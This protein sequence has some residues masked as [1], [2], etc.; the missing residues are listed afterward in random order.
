M[1]QVL[2][3][4]NYSAFEEI[5]DVKNITTSNV[6]T[7]AIY[8]EMLCDKFKN[9]G[10]SGKVRSDAKKQEQRAADIR[11]LSPRVY[12]IKYGGVSAYDNKYRTGT[13]NGQNYMSSEDFAAYYKDLRRYKMPHYYS[14]PSFE[15]DKAD[16]E[17]QRQAQEEAG[18]LPKK[19]LW[20]AMIREQTEKIK[21]VNAEE[22]KNFSYEWF[23][24]DSREDRREVKGKRIP[25][26]I[27]PTFALVTISLFMIVAS[28]VMVSREHRQVARLEREITNLEEIKSELNTKLEIKDNM[29]MI[30]EI[31]VGRYGMVSREYVNSKYID[32]EGGEYIDAYGKKKD[33]SM[34]ASILKAIGLKAE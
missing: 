14:R 21:R 33:E 17:A 11:K 22:L 30:K 26:K 29:I 31:A 1:K 3:T 4:E 8:I 32:L 5:R 2:K 6:D 25:K 9:R 7:S 23:P 12:D 20:L 16:I 34:L 18:T 19:A 24:V 10:I 27:I 13:Y 28:S 15:Y